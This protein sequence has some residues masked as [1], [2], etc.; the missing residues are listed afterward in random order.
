[1]NSI[2]PIK[3]YVVKALPFKKQYIDPNDI[4]LEM[5]EEAHKIMAKVVKK[6]GNRHLPL[7]IKIH[8]EIED[9][10][11]ELSYQGIA[12]QIASNDSQ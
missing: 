10:K 6:Y 11:K 2:K 9:R 7:F 12:L 4:D 3:E 8:N 1:M 5:L